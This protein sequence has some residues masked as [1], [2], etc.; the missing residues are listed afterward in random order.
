[1]SAA[2]RIVSRRLGAAAGGITAAGVA[3]GLLR[4]GYAGWLRTRAA[5]PSLATLG[6]P[7]ARSASY[8]AGGRRRGLVH[9]GLIIVPQQHAYIVQRFGR[10]HRVL[11]PGLHFL[12]PLVDKVAFTH[13]LKE[14][15]I[16][17][18]S[19]TAITRDNVTIAIDGVLYARVVDAAKASYGVE[20]PYLALTLLAQTT[21]R[22]ELGKLTLDKTFEEREVLNTRIVNSINEAAF[23]WGMQCLRYEIRDISPPANVRKAMEL[24]AEAERRKRAQILD[25]EG[26]KESEINVA[27]GQKRATILNSEALK[28]EQINR[29]TGEAEAILVRARATADA[30]R[31]VAAEMH[32]QGGSDAVALRVAEQYVQ[33]LANLAKEGTTLVVPAN[34]ADARGVITQALAIW[35]GVGSQI[36]QRHARNAGDLTHSHEPKSVSPPAG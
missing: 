32:Q 23:A 17:I 35:E 22:S 33:A 13:S 2:A 26:E 4:S 3:G 8:M 27:E 21:M 34:V 25:S 20:D 19:Q 28:L 16:P 10:F 6:V 36:R 7:G 30:I 31:M 29:A 14:E 18:N 24:Q 5:Q 9:F 1:M 11:D 15:A 12:I